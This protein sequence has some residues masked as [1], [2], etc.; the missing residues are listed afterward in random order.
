[1]NDSAAATAKKPVRGPY[2]ADF[3]AVCL[4]QR[5]D[6]YVFGHEVRFDDP[7]PDVFDCSEL[8][9]WAARRLG[10]RFPDG[11]WNQ[12]AAVKHV[13]VDQAIATQGALLFRHR[14][15]SGHVAVSLGNGSTIEA[16]G[17]AYG[18][19][20]F[21]ARGRDWT[22]A[23]LIRGLKYRRPPH[24]PHVPTPPWP[25]RYLMQPPTMEGDD[26][27]AWQ[28]RM[29]ERSYAIDVDGAYGPQT[30]GVC[31]KFQQAAGLTVDGIVGPA[32]WEAAFAPTG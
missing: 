22:S 4:R 26:V 21:S 16:R 7:D 11:S 14:G 12:D 30:D 5:G 15:Q 25:G 3:V 13:T 23:G 18:V 10:V 9:E 2:A 6:R 17:R 28:Q 8:V 24:S 27:R 1:M 31:R 20:V 32:T 29:R 19:N